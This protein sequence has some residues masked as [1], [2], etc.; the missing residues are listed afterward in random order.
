MDK[1]YEAYLEEYKEIIKQIIYFFD[2]NTRSL[3]K[4]IISQI[5]E[6]IKKE[7][8][9]RAAKLRDIHNTIDQISQSQNVVIEQNIS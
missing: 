6:A 2:G 7:N 3:K 8:F 9:E 1:S 5:Q 4:N